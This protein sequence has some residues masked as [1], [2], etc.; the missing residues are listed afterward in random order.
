MPNDVKL[1]DENL[2]PIE[3]F[4]TL[5]KNEFSLNSTG[6]NKQE[7]PLQLEISELSKQAYSLLKANNIEQSINV[8][9]KILQL[10]STNNYALV[11]LG[12]A[13]RKNNNFDKAIEFYKKCL[14][15]HPANNYALFGLADCYK[16]TNQ[17]YKAISIWEKYIK[18]DD[19]N[20]TVLTRIADAYRKNKNFEKAE[21]IYL[22]VLEFSPQNAYALIGLGHLNYDFKKY[23]EA[24]SYW[25]EVL[26][27]SGQAADIR[28]LTSV[29]NCYRKL[30]LFDKGVRYFERALEQEPKN[31]YGLFGLADCYRGLNQQDKSVIYWQ[32]I[33]ETDPANKVI[34]TRVGDAYRSLGDFEKAKIYYQKAL[35]IDFDSYAMLGLAILCK[36][37]K[38]YDEA[39]TTLSHLKDIKE[40]SCRVYLELAQCYIEKKD[41]QKAI[42]ILQEFQKKG[43]KNQTVSDLLLE[44]TKNG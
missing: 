9:N 43:I 38:K 25:E 26:Q 3:N 37:Q 22:K 2:N 29:G 33:L 32:K 4:E 18:F 11:G 16:S 41:K 14:E 12:D 21:T 20:I 31:F 13:E 28:V 15:Y 6:E 24:L 40:L 23:R 27:F 34:L 7:E 36:L 8:F 10:D 39:I 30:K 1:T 19:K 44:L 17:F 42:D 35:D 5:E